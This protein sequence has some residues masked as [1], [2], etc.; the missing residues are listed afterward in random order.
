LAPSSSSPPESD[1]ALA[2]LLRDAPPAAVYV[3]ALSGG[4]DSASLLHALHRAGLPL[5][6]VHVHHGLQPAA[7]AFA[8]TCRKQCAALDV[9]LKVHTVQV[10]TTGAGLEAD[11]RAARYAALARAVPENGVLITAHHA[12]D[13][14]ETVLMRVLRG[15]GIDGLAAMR[16]LAT[17]AN[18]LRIWRPWLA[19]D[20][21]VIAAYAAQH[22]LH[23]VDDPHNRDPAFAR[24][25]LRQTVLPLL[26]TRFPGTRSALNRLA[27]LAAVSSHDDALPD[28][29]AGHSR[30][31]PCLSLSALQ[32]LSEA[33]QNDALRRWLRA[34][35]GQVP[36]RDGL[37]RLRR[38]V[39][40]A[41]C[42]RQPQL[43][44]C[45]FWVRRH[46]ARL[47]LT[48]DVAPIA[49]ALWQGQCQCPV[50]G[51][52]VLCADRPPNRPLQV[53]APQPGDRIRPSGDA[54]HQRLQTLFQA[55]GIPPWARAGIPVLSDGPRIVAV[56]D[57]VTAD[58]APP[59]LRWHACDDAAYIENVTLPTQ[60][61][62]N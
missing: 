21:V 1:A 16:R 5:K 29:L 11:A 56:A 50:S 33:D 37:Q 34:V 32:Y 18:G 3:L 60:P 10:T 48:G 31:G 2:A 12:G 44:L 53:R 47:Y 41:R 15:T 55:R 43:R 61:P 62:T 17:R 52:G 36:G 22:G 13:Q 7:D 51:A 8:A 54:H 30:W 9:T 38:E 39:I 20:P 6:A 28:G 58:G 25:W 57:W 24:V 19:L 14:A 40:G 35:T 23:W 46:R 4:R 42:D 26:E 49:P 45:G 27:D 59:G